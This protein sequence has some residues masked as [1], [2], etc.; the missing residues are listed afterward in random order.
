[1]ACTAVPPNHGQLEPNPGKP[2][3][4]GHVVGGVRSGIIVQL[5]FMRDCLVFVAVLK[6]FVGARLLRKTPST[7]VLPAPLAVQLVACSSSSTSTSTSTSSSSSS[8][9]PT[10]TVCPRLSWKGAGN[11]RRA[12]VSS[13]V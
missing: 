4:D 6:F 12:G 9:R 3:A 2:S 11:V 7:E 13:V 10:L 8:R 5:P 1:M